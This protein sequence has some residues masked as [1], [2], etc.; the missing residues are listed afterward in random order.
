MRYSTRNPAVLG[1]AIAGLAIA[2]PRLLRASKGH[3][4]RDCTTTA[5]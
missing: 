3:S 2:L 4:Y 5:R 1:L